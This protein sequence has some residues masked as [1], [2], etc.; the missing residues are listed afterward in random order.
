MNV[1]AWTHFTWQDFFPQILSG[2]DFDNS[3][4]VIVTRVNERWFAYKFSDSGH[5]S[6]ISQNLRRVKIGAKIVHRR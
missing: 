3:H 5:L 4:F 2:R 1:S 6:L